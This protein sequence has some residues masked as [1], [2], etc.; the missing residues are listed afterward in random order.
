MAASDPAREPTLERAMPA[1]AV[2]G[3]TIPEDTEA[4]I[5]LQDGTWAWAQV[6]GQRKDRHGRWCVGLRWYASPSVG[7]RE[8]WYLYDPALIRR[9][10]P[11]LSTGCA[12]ISAGRVQLGL[13]LGG[14][15]ASGPVDRVVDRQAARHVR[16]D[17]DDRSGLSRV[18]IGLIRG[19]EKLGD[20]GAAYEV[21]AAALA[22]LEALPPAARDAGQR[23]ELLMAAL[24]LARTRPGR[25]QG[26]DPA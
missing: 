23:Q 5:L 13:G 24:R 21:A 9:P 10:N 26:S 1:D 17:L 2:P 11:A 19:L 20:P 16:G 15:V 3:S 18:Q 4:E 6:T 14:L 22:E 12:G 8:G 7:G 25:D